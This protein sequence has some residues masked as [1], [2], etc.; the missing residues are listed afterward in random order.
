MLT[1]GESAAFAQQGGIITFVLQD[2]RL[3]FDID[4]DAATRAGLH[5]SAQ[6]QK[7]ARTVKSGR[8][9]PER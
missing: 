7:L 5:I 6:L 8:Q 2:D 9:R 4:M 3:R 1:V